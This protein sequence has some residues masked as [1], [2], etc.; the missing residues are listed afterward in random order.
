MEEQKFRKLNVWSKS[1]DFIEQIYRTTQKFPIQETYGLTSQLRRASTS[2][3]LNIAEGSGSGTDRE[4]K[5]FLNI[6][7]R[8]AYE[9]I[10][11][12]EIA[13]RLGFCSM[14]EANA[15]KSGGEEISAMLTGLKKYLGESKDAVHA[16]SD[17]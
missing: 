9:A 10:C 16:S 13:K 7:L 14:R 11:A 8:S 4:F 1:M 17:V 6:A 15:L 5:R 3:A 12:I 2:I